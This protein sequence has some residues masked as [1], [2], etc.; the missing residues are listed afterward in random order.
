MANATLSPY[1]ERPAVPKSRARL[2][3]VASETQTLWLMMAPGNA[4]RPN[5]RYGRLSANLDGP[6]RPVEYKLREFPV[7]AIV[8]P[9]PV[10]ATNERLGNHPTV[11]RSRTLQNERDRKLIRSESSRPEPVDLW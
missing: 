2:S 8:L 7:S 3:M 9:A 5:T 4:Q 11:R 6:N 10:A 1:R